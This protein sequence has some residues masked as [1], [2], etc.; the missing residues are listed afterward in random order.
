MDDYIVTR[1]DIVVGAF[2]EAQMRT[3]RELV[4]EFDSDTPFSADEAGELLAALVEAVRPFVPDEHHDVQPE[5]SHALRWLPVYVADGHPEGEW[6][7]QD[8][9]TGEVSERM[10]KE[11]ATD[12]AERRNG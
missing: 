3:L 12:E 6:A 7:V 1:Y 4:A 5:E 8:M 10:T 11:Q 9:R 2:T